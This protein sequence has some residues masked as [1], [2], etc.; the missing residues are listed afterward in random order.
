MAK[1]RRYKA[2]STTSANLA[3]EAYEQ[4]A[5]EIVFEEEPSMEGGGLQDNL[6]M[7]YGP[8]K[9]GK[10]KLCHLIPGVYFLPTEPGLSWL[11]CR[12]TRIRNWAT[13]KAF[14]KKMERS[15]KKCKSVKMWCIDTGDN[16]AKFCMQYACGRAKIA[17]P[18]DQQWG[19]GWEAFRDEFTH[20]I[21]RLGTLGPG[22][23]VVSHETEREIVTHSKTLTK[24]SP[25]LP[26]T[27]YTVLNNLADIILRMGWKIKKKKTRRG[28]T[29]IVA[30]DTE[31][32]CL[33]TRPNNLMDAGDRTELLPDVIFFTKESEAVKALMKAFGQKGEE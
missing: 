19:K 18:S 10:S 17:H 33:F 21:L 26:K 24:I 20:W 1:K 5:D 8:P 14:V 28:K 29:K 2:R 16:L 9:I 12:K 11:K 30:E 31:T 6:I 13:F 22:I 32:R 25:A 4:E 23:V 7:L 27:C 15:P 3:A